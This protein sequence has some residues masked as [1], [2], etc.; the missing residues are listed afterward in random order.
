[1]MHKLH[2]KAKSIL[3]ILITI[4]VTIGLLFLS[5]YNKSQIP[6]FQEFDHLLFKE[7]L[8]QDGLSSHFLFSD[9]RK[10]DFAITPMLPSYTGIRNKQA[11]E[12]LEKKIAT[13]KQIKPSSNPVTALDQKICMDYLIRMKNLSCYPYLDEPL[14]PNGG[15]HTE[16]LLLL[17]AYPFYELEDVDHYFSLLKSFDSFTQNLISYENEK[18][19]QGLFMSYAACEQVMKQCCEYMNNVDFDNFSSVSDIYQILDDPETPIS[20][21]TESFIQRLLPFY[22]QGHL[23]EAELL[24][25]L[26]EHQLILKNIVAPCYEQLT[27]ALWLLADNSIPTKGLATYPDGKKYYLALLSYETGSTK[28]IDEMKKL[29]TVNLH[30]TYDELS[31]K[32]NFYLQKISDSTF[33]QQFPIIS[34]AEQIQALQEMIAKDFPPLCDYC[35]TEISCDIAAVSN[36]LTPY[37]APAFYIQTPIDLL[38]SQKIYVNYAQTNDPLSLFTTLSHEGYP[39]HMYQHIIS[40]STAI[41]KRRALTRTIFSYPGFQEG[42]AVYVE[43]YA[44]E[45]AKDFCID[46]LTKEYINL[47]TLDR[48][49]SL[50]LYALADIM[51]HYEGADYPA[52]HHFFS[53]Y[54]ITSPDTTNAIYTYIAS[55][56]SNYMKYYMGY[57]EI[58]ECKELAKTA[59]KEH[60]SDYAFHK[61]LLEFGSAPFDIIKEEIRT[62]SF[63]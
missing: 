44:Y 27:D 24:A 34:V 18:K 33:Y 26:H 20:F 3:V 49:T 54:G 15:L 17:C 57:L 10:F 29:L 7:E 35:D 52:I 37:T 11:F 46:P 22:E 36:G 39:G 6:S 8:T 50:C 23:S 25:V 41:Q 56:P 4:L 2:L 16:I 14:S 5:L 28:T 9:S 30:A 13:L 51:I 38:T 42:W 53:D 19:A 55:S 62:S 32:A 31:Q 61:Y 48:K 60:Y 12:S 40:S 47:I 59:W 1:M 43:F 21:L 58:L 45:H 63:D